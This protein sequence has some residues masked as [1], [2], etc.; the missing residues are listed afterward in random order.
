VTDEL[1]RFLYE[2]KTLRVPSPV[3]MQ[4]STYTLSLP[5]T[6]AIPLMLSY[7]LLHWLVSQSVF[8]VQTSAYGSGPNGQRIHSSDASRIGFSP[9]GILLSIFLGTAMLMGLILNSLR[10]YQ[11]VPPELPRM[12]TNSTPISAACQTRRGYR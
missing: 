8:I 4:R 11:P 3:G 1:I 7:I 5:W 2:K 10:K 9:I 12:V 6:Y